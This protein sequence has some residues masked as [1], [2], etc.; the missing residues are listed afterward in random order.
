MRRYHLLLALPSALMLVGYGGMLMHMTVEPAPAMAVILEEDPEGQRAI[1]HSDRPVKMK[2]DGEAQEVSEEIPNDGE[3]GLHTVTWSTSYMGKPEKSISHS[4]L[5][6]P[7][8]KTGWERHGAR[9]SIAQDVLDDG[10]DQKKGDLATALI[11]L[12]K[13]ILN[14][15]HE[16]KQYAGEVS[17]IQ[18]RIRIGSRHIAIASVVVFLDRASNTSQLSVGLRLTPSPTLPPR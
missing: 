11:P 18:L 1:V 4:Y 6:G 10:D 5:T 17:N 15:N 9:L 12:F 13:G 3:P 16:L 8:G 2:L 7:F 14:D